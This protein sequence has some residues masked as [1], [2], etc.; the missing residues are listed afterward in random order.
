MRFEHTA[1]VPAPP[2]RLWDFLMDIKTVGRCIP[3][4]EEVREIDADHYVAV[5]RVKVGPISLRFEGKMTITE[6]D[7]GARRAAMTVEG[8][9]KGAGGAV[10]ATITVAIKALGP[11]ESQLI[12]N[13]DVQV[14]GKLG[15]YG[16]P[17]M[18][19]KADSIMA[20]FAQNLGRRVTSS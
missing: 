12:V 3:G 9:D 18:R 8:A 16:Q 7:R 20:E 2:D 15:E 4:V 5:Q 17:V 19:K 14:L 1:S 13:T 10:K 11:N 6:R